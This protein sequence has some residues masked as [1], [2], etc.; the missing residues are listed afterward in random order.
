MGS[1][2]AFFVWVVFLRGW[3]WEGGGGGEGDLN[4]TLYFRNSS[5]VI[6]S[7]ERRALFLSRC[8]IDIEINLSVYRLLFVPGEEP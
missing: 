1:H 3:G 4:V 7:T 5:N 2:T 6:I 8:H